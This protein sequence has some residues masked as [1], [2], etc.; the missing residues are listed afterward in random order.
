MTL[1]KREFSSSS[2]TQ[3]WLSDVV[4]AVAGNRANLCRW[5]FLEKGI[6]SVMLKLEE[7]VDMKTVCSC[8]LSTKNWLYGCEAVLTFKLSS[9][10]T[11]PC[12][13]MPASDHTSR[14][15]SLFSLD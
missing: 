12:T 13:R 5:T 14:Y 11:W 9:C 1:T 15:V 2:N 10:S 8:V 4:A 6:N 3:Y 7:G